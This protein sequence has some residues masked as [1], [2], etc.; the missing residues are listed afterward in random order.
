MTRRALLV[1][2]AI[3]T[4]AL[5]M[6]AG[7]PWSDGG[8]RPLLRSPTVA[9]TADTASKQK[10]PPR[11]TA[12]RPPA[13]RAA[14]V[15]LAGEQALPPPG[16]ALELIQAE[17]SDRARRGDA[18][19]ASRLFHD[20]RVCLHAHQLLRRLAAP[21]PETG[22]DSEAFLSGRQRQLDQLAQLQSTCA[23]V[24]TE[25]D[26]GRIYATSLRAAELG[27][28]VAACFYLNAPFL[29]DD[30]RLATMFTDYHDPSVAREPPHLDAEIVAT[31]RANASGLLQRGLERGDWNTVLW[32]HGAYTDGGATLPSSPL[33]EDPAQAYRFALLWRLGE[34][35]PEAARDF[36]EA[37]V[38]TRGLSADQVA[39]AQRWAIEMFRTH[40]SPRP[41]LG[42]A[43][44]MC[45]IPPL[46]GLD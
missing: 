32:A 39:A 29:V 10:A 12:E 14:N 28:A 41:A 15:A 37:P 1:A 2:A 19:A 9:G 21:Q 4:L 30:G 42:L 24:D 45:G 26:D 16:T 13:A 23:G 27:D 3:C 25:I 40:F 20:T 22:A 35:D 8:S 34:S 36:S 44:P 5:S 38:E 18:A 46:P 7:W 11:I 6:L 33:Q 43:I 17:L 31:Y